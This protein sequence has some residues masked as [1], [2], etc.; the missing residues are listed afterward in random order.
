[1]A[2]KMTLEKLAL[3][4]MHGF[5]EVHKEINDFRKEMHAELKLVRQEIKILR[6]SHDRRITRLEE[7]V[8]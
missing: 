2:E 3:I 1:M 6:D 7:K 8:L 4:T 5:E